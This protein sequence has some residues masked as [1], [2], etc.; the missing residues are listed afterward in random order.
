MVTLV[1]ATVLVFTMYLSTSTGKGEGIRQ[2]VAGR[3]M[4]TVLKRPGLADF[5]VCKSG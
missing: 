5:S 4:V 3:R 1:T 2:K